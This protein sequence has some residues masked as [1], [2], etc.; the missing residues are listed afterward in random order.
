MTKFDLLFTFTNGSTHICSD[1][2]VQGIGNDVASFRKWLN[3]SAKFIHIGNLIINLDNVISIDAK[4]R[5]E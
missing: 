2:R 4:I 1:V 3:D 5:E